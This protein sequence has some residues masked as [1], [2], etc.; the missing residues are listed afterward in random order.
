MR[1][2]FVSTEQPF[3]QKKKVCEDIFMIIIQF[4]W[5]VITSNMVHII[6]L[7][8]WNFGEMVTLPIFERFSR[9]FRILLDF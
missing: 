3:S 8:L 4:V 5:F 9:K 1:I 7:R 6:C 2:A